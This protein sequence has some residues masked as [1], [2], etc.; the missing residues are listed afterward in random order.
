MKI[1]DRPWRLI[2]HKGGGK[3][4]SGLNVKG[5]RKLIGGKRK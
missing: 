3:G 4:R 2:N 5:G 1:L